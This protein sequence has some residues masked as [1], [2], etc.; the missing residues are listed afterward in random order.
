M[1]I[2]SKPLPDQYSH[3]TRSL[4]YASAFWS[5]LISL[6]LSLSGCE[7]CSSETAMATLSARSGVVDRDTAEKLEQWLKAEV[8]AAFSVGDG[9]RT[10]PKSGAELT[11]DDGSILALEEDTLIRFLDRPPGSKE[12]ALDLQLGNASLEAPEDGTVLRTLFGQATLTGGT[13]VQLGRSDGGLRFQIK[14]GSATLENAEGQKLEVEAGQ[15]IQISLGGAVMEPIEETQKESPDE[16][17]ENEE[18]PTGPV[19]AQVRGNTVKLKGP[20]ESAFESLAAGEAS[21]DV[22][23]TLQVGSGS[24]VTL[25]QGDDKAD[26][27]A[28]GTYVIGGGGQFVE[29]QSGSMEVSSEGKV[30]IQVPGGVI[31]TNGGSSKITALGKEGTKVETKSGSVTLRGKTEE[32]LST[33]EEGIITQQGDIS[34]K[35]RGLSYADVETASGENLVIHDPRPPT[36]VRFLFGD[37]CKDGVIR[38]SGSKTSVPQDSFGRGEGSVALLLGNGATSYT[39]HCIGEDGKEGAAK[40][41]GKVTVLQDAGSRPV[42]KTAPFTLVDVNGRTYTV[43]YQNQLPQV[44]VRWSKAPEGVGSFKLHVSGPGGKRTYTTSGPSYGFRS[45]ALSEG[46]HSVYFEGGGRVSRQTRITILFDNATPTASLSTPT[47]L[48]A[49][50]GGEVVLAGTALPGWDVEVDGQSIGQDAGSRFSVKTKV[51]ENG[52]PVAVR[53]TH[54]TRGTH[55]Y[56]RRAGD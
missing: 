5:V 49:N 18:Q 31:V 39:L 50:P 28:G 22:G 35:G 8:G 14:V 27:A 42:P 40:V 23:S 33:G 17:K 25:I 11:L 45:G 4:G 54:P 47:E 2:S 55:I 3:A 38:L 1:Q 44:S 53:L 51:P 21:L 37:H 36:A 52:R 24:S 30:T 29:A 15:T 7:R 48:K 10:G 16:K 34:V 26:L 43:L 20:G 6:L 19:S 32:T 46:T 13:R 56:L 9:V 12:Q 41:K